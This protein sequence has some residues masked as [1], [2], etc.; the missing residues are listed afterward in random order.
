MT[1]TE[2][3]SGRL[4]DPQWYRRVLGQYPTGVCVVTALSPEHGPCG[5]V[6]GSFTSV[7]LDPPLVA[8]YPA[9]TSTSWP[10]IASAGHFCVNILS[11]DQEDV[12]RTFFAAAGDKFGHLETY[13][14]GSG[15]PIIEGVVGWIDC[16]VEHVQD[17]GDHL[18]VLGR[19]RSL[20]TGATALPLLFF[21]GGYGRFAPMSLAAPDAR[22][23]LTEPLRHVDLARPLMERFAT[24]FDCQCIA[25]SRLDDEVVVVASAGRPQDNSENGTLVGQRMPYAPP[26]GSIFAAWDGSSQTEAWLDQ[27]PQEPDRNRHRQALRSVAQRGV[28]LGLLT[29]AQREFA[30][31]L[32]SLAGERTELPRSLLH[33]LIQ[34]LSYDPVHLTD[35]TKESVRQISAPVFNA[36][37][38]VALALTAFGFGRPG[39]GIDALTSGLLDIAA[40]ATRRIGGRPPGQL[41]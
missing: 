39:S 27:T 18:M 6:V 19:V 35:E 11:A 14:A 23:L 34:Q 21:Q 32:E 31:T 20:D 1:S 37:G 25:T 22:G 33:A 16:D 9:R 10:K 28:S 30:S 8:F 41:T 5:M 17:A 29:A 26:M 12:C 7:S 2:A 24:E 13:P 3:A 4:V 36:E 15:A 40:A 38:S